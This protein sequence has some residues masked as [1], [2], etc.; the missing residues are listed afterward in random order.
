MS[1]C[2]DILQLK[3]EN[4]ASTQKSTCLDS[5]R[6]AKHRKSSKYADYISRS[7]D[8][9]IF[10]MASETLRKAVTEAIDPTGKCTLLENLG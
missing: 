5:L 1:L 9:P 3:R 8:V 4:I 6:R 2:L 7:R 10:H